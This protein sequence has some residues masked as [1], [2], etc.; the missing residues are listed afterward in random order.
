MKLKKLLMASLVGAF[1]FSSTTVY[2]DTLSHPQSILVAGQE[3]QFGGV[4]PVSEVFLEFEDRVKIV[5]RY[6]L[7]FDEPNAIPQMDFIQ[8]GFNFTLDSLV[9]LGLER[10]SRTETKEIQIETR[11]SDINDIMS[12][13][14]STYSW[15]WDGYS[16]ELDVILDSIYTT[17][18]PANYERRT[19]TE[20]QTYFN[21]MYGDISNIARTLTRNGITHNLTDIIWS[22]N[23]EPIDFRAVPRTFNATAIYT[24]TYT[25]RIIPGFITTVTYSGEVSRIGENPKFIYEATFAAIRSGSVL[26]LY[27]DDAPDDVYYYVDNLDIDDI[28]ALETPSKVSKSW[29][30]IIN[31]IFIGLIALIIAGFIVVKIFRPKSPVGSL[32]EE[33]SNVSHKS[34]TEENVEDDIPYYDEE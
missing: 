29:A 3:V 11:T 33:N 25:R 28:S 1:L 22:E 8:D 17:P 32:H 30:T 7:T 6:L 18:L 24:G 21:I 5:R 9:S 13:I 10:S 26:D 31:W 16:G 20:R 27:N 4:T 12:H 15:E 14:S 2:A 23:S 19:L 34:N